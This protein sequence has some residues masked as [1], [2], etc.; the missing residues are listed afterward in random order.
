MSLLIVDDEDDF[1]ES[2]RDVFED[3]GYDVAVAANGVEAMARLDDLAEVCL[4]ILDL[5]MPRMT[6]GEVYEAMQANP[7]FARIPVII[8]TSDPTGAP[9]GVPTMTKPLKLD[10]LRAEAAKHCRHRP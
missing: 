9:A 1:R 5:H 3:D 8:A 4:V 7:R 2:L 6:G 10:V